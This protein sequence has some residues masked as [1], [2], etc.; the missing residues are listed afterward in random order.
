MQ[1]DTNNNLRIYKKN[2]IITPKLVG[3]IL[4]VYNGNQWIKL[5][6]EEIMVGFKIGEFILTRKKPIWPK[7]KNKI[8]KK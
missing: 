7:K 6:V 4:F 8:N 3:Q 5:Q 2:A 1:D